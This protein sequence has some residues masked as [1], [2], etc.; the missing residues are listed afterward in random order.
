MPKKRWDQEIVNLDPAVLAHPRSSG[1]VVAIPDWAFDTVT[2][3]SASKF[4][5]AGVCLLGS[6]S[7]V[8]SDTLND[9]HW[10][11]DPSH[12]LLEVLLVSLPRD[13]DVHKHVTSWFA[14]DLLDN[15]VKG[16]GFF[17]SP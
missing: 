7:V 8:A 6:Y 13:F 9:L 3:A 12:L 16:I 17:R 1:Q 10:W 2:T 14:V 11:Q 5:L 4:L 15:Q